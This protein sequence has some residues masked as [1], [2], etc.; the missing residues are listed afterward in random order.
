MEGYAY[1]AYHPVPDESATQPRASG[2]AAL[3][4]FGTILVLLAAIIP[5]LYFTWHIPRP[6][7]PPSNDVNCGHGSVQIAVVEEL[8]SRAA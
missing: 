3:V 1:V 5:A 2:I 7:F 4:A 6:Y 8:A